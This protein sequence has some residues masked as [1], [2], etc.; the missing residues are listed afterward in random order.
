MVS[1]IHLEDRISG[2]V[3]WLSVSQK[4]LQEYIFTCI[5]NI[6]RANQNQ[7]SPV[8]RYKAYH[9]WCKYCNYCLD[10]AVAGW[11]LSYQVPDKPNPANQ[12][13]MSPRLILHTRVQLC[14]FL[15]MMWHYPYFLSTV[16][17]RV[18]RQH[19]LI[20]VDEWLVF[21]LSWFVNQHISFELTWYASL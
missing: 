19:D 6:V 3:D 7:L 5:K 18:I 20:N 1:Y 13:E 16:G 2:L 4:N 11:Q 9:D 14:C 21:F 10:K 17:K 15:L 8:A 12:S